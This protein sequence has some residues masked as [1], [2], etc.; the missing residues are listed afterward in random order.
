MRQFEE[1]KES[2]FPKNGVQER[3]QN[4]LNFCGN[5]EIFSFLE[6]I[7]SAID[8]MENELIILNLD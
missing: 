5:G 1:V 8:P 4:F 6:K 7:K 3:S 2:L